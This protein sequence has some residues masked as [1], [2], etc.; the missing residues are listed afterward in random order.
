MM[1]FFVF[2]IL[3]LMSVSTLANS[4]SAQGGESIR[5]EKYFTI[6][7]SEFTEL[8]VDEESIR[9][10]TE[11]NKYL[12]CDQDEAPT[13]SDDSNS[14][15][16]ADSGPDSDSANDDIRN[17]DIAAATQV[18][19]GIINIGQKMWDIIQK[20]K[21]VMNADF[22]NSASA[23]PKSVDCWDKLSNWKMP[24][25]KR[26]S[27]SYK[28]GFG[29]EVVRFEFDVVY[30][31]GGQYNSKGQYL[32]NVQVHPK[33]IHVAWGFNLDAKVNIPSIVNMGSED[34]PVAGMQVDVNW[35]TSS[36]FVEH[37]D[38]ASVFIQGNGEANIL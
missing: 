14:N 16:G 12:A 15:T 5:G 38:S 24:S 22:Q 19:D 36:A 35:Q 30:T 10:Y 23:I 28:N 27:Q 37:M 1:K 17:L 33:R 21:A 8:P 32:M 2:I 31:H 6:M 18:V 20:G 26:Y 25:V 9:N 4:A 7:S 13:A 29:S 34:D 3:G 11:D